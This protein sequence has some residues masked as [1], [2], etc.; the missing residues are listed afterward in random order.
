MSGLQEQCV[1]QKQA[2]AHLEEELNADLEE[3]ELKISALKMKVRPKGS[4][5]CC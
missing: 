4:R 1:L 2:K 3:K 5:D